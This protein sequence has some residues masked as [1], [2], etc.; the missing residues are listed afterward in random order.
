V[1]QLSQQGR[2][3][4]ST[5]VH[6]NAD[7]VG[8][9][10]AL[11]QSK[12]T[13]LTINPTTGLPEAFNLGGFL[14]G[15]LPTI[16]GAVGMMIPGVNAVLNPMTMGMLVGAGKVATGGSLTE[17]LMAGL[18]AYSGAGLTTS[19]MSAGSGAAAGA[20]GA[21]VPDAANTA[22]FT[23]EQVAAQQA[24]VGA[25]GGLAADTGA[26]LPAAA[27]VAGAVAPSVNTMG[28]MFTGAGQGVAPAAITSAGA[29]A[30]SV[31]TMGPMFTGAG[32]GVA[33][34]AITSAAPTVA[35]GADAATNRLFDAM[36]SGYGSGLS[37]PAA[38]P[39]FMGNLSNAGAGLK[40][41][42]TPAPAG[43]TPAEIAARHK[44]QMALVTKAGIPLAGSAMAG[45]TP[46]GG[47]AP[48]NSTYLRPYLGPGSFAGGAPVFPTM[49]HKGSSEINYFPNQRIGSAY[50]M[51][52]PAQV[53]AYLAKDP[54]AKRDA[55]GK[56]NMSSDDRRAMAAD[57]A[58]LAQFGYAKGGVNLENGAFVVDARTVSELGN[59][60]SSA[61]QEFLAKHGGQ[62]I[63]GKG[64]GVSDSIHANIGGT[65]EARVARDEVKFSP[66]SVARIGGGDQKRGARKLYAMMDRAAKS[67]KAATRGE[68]TGLRGLMAIR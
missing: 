10:Q 67:R 65:Q 43:A 25:M 27:N 1:Q 51:H 52:D 56:I 6:M 40:S 68:D 33:P 24:S 66:Q 48:P 54:F 8:G 49:D 12:G 21:A 7:E 18:G 59:G 42:I 47:G 64:D 30:P 61:G 31:N 29:V 9:L 34:A 22:G 20:A 55:F 63:H 11:A 45:M 5:L 46:S 53:S 44:L 4:D 37:A 19:L 35:A 58:S 41:A 39:S 13:S 16:I 38:A 57:Q 32:Q 14:K 26:A 2:Y 36:G 28:P 3:G 50:L 15:M 17:G 23:A 62:P 60:S